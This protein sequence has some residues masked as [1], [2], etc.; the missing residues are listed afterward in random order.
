VKA[1]TVE[2]PEVGEVPA[3]LVQPARMRA[4]FVLG[5]GAGAGMRHAFMDAIATALAERGIGS[6]RYAFPYMHR[7]HKRPDPRPRLLATVRAAVAVAAAHAGDR[8][9]LAGGK[10]MGG[11]MTSLAAAAEPLP[12]VRALVFLGFPL[13]AAGKP[14]TG[15]AEHLGHVPLPLLFVQGTRDALARLDLVTGVVEH[16]G[17]RARLHVVDGA[18]HGFAVLKRSGRTAE[19][20]MAE[21]ADTVAAFSTTTPSAGS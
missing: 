10:S 14:D 1:L 9:L 15:R 21:I 7:G 4:L 2:V 8:P 17:A 12:G 3:L 11:R 18:D 16:L 6:F 13:H 19:Q 5:H 20:V